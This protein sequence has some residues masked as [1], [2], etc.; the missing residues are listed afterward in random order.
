M[1]CMDDRPGVD[2]AA[3]RREY[4]VGRLD[5]AEVAADPFTQFDRW[6]L[7]AVAT[8]GLEPHAMTLSTS[9]TDGEVSARTVLLKGVDAH[10]FV[11]AT[12][13]R[14]RKGLDLAANPRAALT[15]HWREIERQVCITGTARRTTA[16]ESD[17]IFAARSRE[18]QVASYASP[19]GAVLADRAELDALVTAVAL[20]FAGRG[21]PRPRHWGGVRVRPDAVEF[22]QGGPARLHDRVRYRRAGRRWVVERLAP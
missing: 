15:F 7:A 21:V 18:A 14:S 17:A 3:L 13:Y 9:T 12:N 10:G 1:V 11:F 16:A 2:L 5:L 22:W 20:R 19:Q 8:R 4:G 6:L